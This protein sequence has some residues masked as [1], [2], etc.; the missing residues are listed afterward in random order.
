MAKTLFIPVE[1]TIPL[2]WMAEVSH[3][4]LRIP[5]RPLLT[6]HAVC[7]LSRNQEYPIGRAR[8]DFGFSP[9]VS[10]DEGLARTITWLKQELG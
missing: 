9:P 2:A 3:R 7:V 10:F 1:G 8:Q 4:C 6:R 5:G